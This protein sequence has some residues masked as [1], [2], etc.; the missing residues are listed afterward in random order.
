MGAFDYPD[1]AHQR[2]HGPVYNSC[3]PYRDWLRDEFTFRCV[4][5]LIREQWTRGAAEFDIE[6]WIAQANDPAKEFD[7]DNLFYSCH[8]C[9]STKGTNLI[10][11]PG[12]FLTKANVE[13]NPIDVHVSAIGII[14]VLVVFALTI[15][16]Q[17]SVTILLDRTG[18]A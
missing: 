6:H 1:S 10:P 2:R 12:Q 15:Q 16:H 7:Y 13:V 9:N 17:D 18:I 5:C 11:D 4:Y 8:L 3:P 14:T